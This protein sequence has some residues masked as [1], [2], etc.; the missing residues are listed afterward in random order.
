MSRTIID[1]QL[2]LSSYAP[3]FALL[4]LRF[5]GTPLRIGCFVIAG[6]G[7]MALLGILKGIGGSE[8]KQYRIERIEDKGDDVAGY[9]V[10]YLLPFLTVAM[11][12]AL[13]IAAYALFIAIAGIIYVRS[14]LIYVNPL[15]YVLG[16]RL[17]AVTAAPG[18]NAMLIDKHRPREGSD[19]W[20][21]RF[22]SHLL[23]RSTPP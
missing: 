7:V 22:R 1:T 17:F 11:P 3:L 14:G 18:F 20:V 19:V 21:A 2:F 4:G 9:L 5:D 10:T 23:V 15:L 8:P 6:L 12:S 16:Y 13:D